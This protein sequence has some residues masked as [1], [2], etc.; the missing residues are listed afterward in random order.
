VRRSLAVS[1][2]AASI[3]GLGAGPAWADDGDD[4]AWVPVPDDYWAPFEVEACGDT[5][6]IEGGDVREAEQR[7][8]VRDDGT[9]VT[10]FR[11]GATVDLTRLSDGAVIDELDISGRG[12]EV[13]T[14]RGDTTTI[15]NTLFGASLLFPFG[16]PIEQEAFEEAG[17]PDL[18]YYRDPDDV[19]TLRITVDSDDG[20]LLALA[21]TE[22]DADL[23]NLCKR[24]DR[25][26]RHGHDHDEDDD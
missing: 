17:I 10:R 16:D 15:R 3:V 2:L 19:V 1:A 6:R 14:T 23:V 11:G 22:V 21:F 12:K 8:V 24:F 13:V 20:G 25:A 26:D 7:E 4:G 18:A 9:V 5:V